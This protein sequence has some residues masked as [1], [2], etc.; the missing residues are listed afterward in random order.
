M[1][2]KY[3]QL[4]EINQHH[5]IF[6]VG[7]S[8][9]SVN[10][11]ASTFIPKIELIR[12]KNILLFDGAN[13]F[14]KDQ[15]FDKRDLLTINEAS[16]IIVTTFSFP[17]EVLA[18]QKKVNIQ[19]SSNEVCTIFELTRNDEIKLSFKFG[20]SFIDFLASYKNGS[21]IEQI[22]TASYTINQEK[23][24]TA[25][26]FQ[27]TQFDML[28]FVLKTIGLD[29]EQIESEDRLF[30]PANFPTKLFFLDDLVEEIP[31]I[32]FIEIF[33]AFLSKLSFGSVKNLDGEIQFYRSLD[34]LNGKS[35]SVDSYS[36]GFGF[37]RYDDK[38]SGTGK[39][40]V[41]YFLDINQIAKNYKAPFLSLWM[42]KAKI[43]N[44]IPIDS[45]FTPV[46]KAAIWIK[47]TQE[48][49]KNTSKSST[50]AIHFDTGNQAITINGKTSDLIYKDALKTPFSIG[51]KISFEIECNAICKDYT[52][53]VFRET[54][55]SGKVIGLLNVV[56]NDKLH[57]SNIQLVDVTIGNSTLISNGTNNHPLATPLQN[58]CNT[59]SFNQAFIHVTVDKIAKNFSIDRNLIDS[60]QT[61]INGKGYLP[62]SQ[63]FP[64]H[65]KILTTYNNQ[66]KLLLGNSEEK[67][68]STINNLIDKTDGAIAKT[69]KVDKKQVI[70]NASRL[71]SILHKKF[72]RTYK[73]EKF[74]VEKTF[75]DAEVTEAIKLY[76]VE[77]K[78][79]RLA[80][81]AKVNIA[82]DNHSNSSALTPYKKKV[83]ESILNG[84]P[85]SSTESTIGLDTSN[86]IYMFLYKGIEAFKD[87][88]ED[89]GG[90]A[91]FTLTGDGYVH[92]LNLALGN[93]A[94]REELIVHEMGHA[95]GLVHTFE[96]T[97]TEINDDYNKKIKELDEKK[98]KDIKELTKQIEKPTTQANIYRHVSRQI[99]N[100]VVQVSKIKTNQ[101]LVAVD[102]IIN[103]DWITMMINAEKESL[104][105][106]KKSLT[107]VEIES[108]Y[109]DSK[110][111]AEDTRD[112][113][114]EDTLDLAMAATEENFLDYEVSKRKSFW[115]WQWQKMAAERAPLKQHSL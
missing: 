101:D 29:I 22:K 92:M 76:E 98:E 1:L 44:D 65:T 87:R 19:V 18:S 110:K 33:S 103:P 61:D 105:Q 94:A 109:A 25:F 58:Y 21:Q 10:D 89:L 84:I 67:D 5:P 52:T 88:A 114:L 30:D 20:S 12:K 7:W 107:Q 90:V 56:P 45:L 97:Q 104:G 82:I 93:P 11:F 73:K 111:R 115:Y 37:D 42:P 77:K 51:E 41:K 9:Y 2:D 47:F 112:K 75:N 32:N 26:K 16:G 113:A 64:F 62:K 63:E 49:G 71:A 43:S 57:T 31:P 28:S 6:N 54:D 108:N 48:K 36:G 53:I 8:S 72:N 74:R 85:L 15:H 70:K 4:L 60:I 27:P 68:I 50:N 99:D 23:I 83:E 78:N 59:K 35:S 66:L 79:Y 17:S 39:L 24:N 69:D 80:L 3:D 102:Q 81:L 46:N 106:P 96:R 40:S 95:F 100:L 14:T 55:S 91:G 13:L 38:K 86:T 34:Q